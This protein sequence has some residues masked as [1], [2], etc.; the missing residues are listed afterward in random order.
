MKIFED[1]EFQHK[2]PS[3]I[4][5]TANQIKMKFDNRKL[6][7]YNQRNELSNLKYWIEY[8]EILNEWE[9]DYNNWNK[10]WPQTSQTQNINTYN[11][12]FIDGNELFEKIDT[13]FNEIFSKFN[14]EKTYTSQ[15]TVID[16]IKND[17]ELIKESFT[18]KVNQGIEKILNIKSELELEGDFGKSISSNKKSSMIGK[19][20]FFTLF[21]ATLIGYGL[22]I[23]LIQ[24][25]DYFKALDNFDKIAFRISI[26]I[27]FALII[28]FFWT[29]YKFYNILSLRYSHLSSF[30]GGGISH[31]NQLLINYPNLQ[32]Q[33][34]SK[35]TNL[36]TDISDILNLI[37]KTKSSPV[38]IKDLSEALNRI[39]EI[40]KNINK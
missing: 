23:S 13:K 33:T 40:T 4:L 20:F 14:F 7:Y 39:G 35:I 2:S 8:N 31:L 12:Y 37:N 17:L 36:F 21:L 27:P 24:F 18:D 15:S 1:T 11:A 22:T 5:S 9:K 32:E 30:I 28:Y 26:S 25:Q 16:G 38:D 3:Q 10:K 19:W 29:Q 34:T 6:V